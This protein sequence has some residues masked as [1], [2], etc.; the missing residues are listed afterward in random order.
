MAPP[1]L[2]EMRLLGWRYF[3]MLGRHNIE[4]KRNQSRPER[5]PFLGTDILPIISWDA[6]TLGSISQKHRYLDSLLSGTTIDNVMGRFYFSTD[7]E[8]FRLTKVM[9]PNK[10]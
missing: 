5:T 2:G 7:F 8:K 1:T 9:W 6:F 4:G 10:Q 3:S